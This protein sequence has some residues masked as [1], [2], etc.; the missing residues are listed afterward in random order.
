MDKELNT[1]IDLLLTVEEIIDRMLVEGAVSNAQL[2]KCRHIIDSLLCSKVDGRERL[3]NNKDNALSDE[4]SVIIDELNS[5]II[6]LKY[7]DKHFSLDPGVPSI[8]LNGWIVLVNKGINK[9]KD[10]QN[11]NN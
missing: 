11:E 4:V 1:E 3:I 9:L 2:E 6:S 7:L 5:C 8:S 10:N